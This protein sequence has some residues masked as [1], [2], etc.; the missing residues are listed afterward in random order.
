MKLIT[1]LLNWCYSVSPQCRSVILSNANNPNEFFIC[2]NKLKINN[3]VPIILFGRRYLI[4][5]NESGHI[6]FSEHDS[7]WRD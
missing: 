4:H 6:V 3:K 7:S 1:R 2:L 5:Q